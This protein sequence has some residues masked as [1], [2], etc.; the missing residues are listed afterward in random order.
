MVNAELSKLDYTIIGL[1]FAISAVF[2]GIYVAIRKQ[3][4]LLSIK[5][6]FLFVGI[7]FLYFLLVS[8]TSLWHLV[9]LRWNYFLVAAFAFAGGVLFT[10]V[11]FVH[12][13]ESAY[14][15]Q[16]DIVLALFLNFFGTLVYYLGY[17]LWS[18][19]TY[20]AELMQ[21][22]G[23]SVG[24]VPLFASSACL[25]FCLP[26][27]VQLSYIFLNN[28]P[29]PIYPQWI[30]P[31]G[32]DLPP[33]DYGDGDPQTRINLQFTTKEEG[34]ETYVRLTLIPNEMILGEFLHVY[35][36]AWNE[37]QERSMAMEL[38]DQFG[39]ANAFRFYAIS[40][41]NSPKKRRLDPAKTA[42]YNRIQN[43][44]IILI[45]RESRYN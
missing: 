23:V 43:E 21:E 41:P 32:K 17:S 39:R 12:R 37:N 34:G 6:F 20:P 4:E 31:L 15:T 25:A 16:S 8:F 9:D 40:G 5:S 33:F 35:F 42:K 27:F 26:F 36:E 14:N 2:G 22:L 44:E 38:T 10:R 18:A 29:Q 30:Y 7:T 28:I 19:Y 3:L 13:D 11:M 1:L 45:E 24:H